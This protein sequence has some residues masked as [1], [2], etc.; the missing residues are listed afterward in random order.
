MAAEE[1]HD[2]PT[3]IG[4]TYT[5]Q[6]PLRATWNSVLS[7]DV[8]MTDTVPVDTASPSPVAVFVNPKAAGG[9]PATEA[10]VITPGKEGGQ[11]CHVARDQSTDAGWRLQPLFGGRVASEV[12]GGTTLA[13]TE[14]A[15]VHVFF[16]DDQGLQ[17]TQLQA[18]GRTWVDP[19]HVDKG[20]HAN[21]RVA[22]SPSGLLVLYGSTPEGDLLTA[23]QEQVGGPFKS[24]VCSMNGAL[25]G[26][27]CSLC[28]TNDHSW[29]LVANVN[30]KPAAYTGVLGGTECTPYGQADDYPGT[31]EEVILGYW[32]N[33]QNSLVFLFVDDDRS[34]HSWSSDA[35]F[36]TPVATPIP[37]SKVKLAAG[38][39]QH[40]DEG[41]TLSL[42]SID[43]QEQLWV[44]HQDPDQPWDDDDGSPRWSPPIALDREVVAVSAD[45]NPAHSPTLFA[46]QAGDA[47]LRVHAKD[48]LTG[49]WRSGSV[50]QA[51]SEMF[52]IE[53]FRTEVN[54]VD[55]KGNPL[56]NHPVTLTLQENQSA[57]DLWIQGTTHQVT[58][59]GP[60][61][62]TTDSTGKL[63]FAILTGAGLAAPTLNLQG[64][65]LPGSHSIAPAGPLHEY[66]SGNGT[67]N[68][69]NPGGPLPTFDADGSTLTAARV[70]GKA[71]SGPVQTNKDLAGVAASAVRNTAQLGLN[72]SLE[73]GAA[74]YVLDLS[75]RAAPR[76]EL[77]E[78]RE[79][80]EL[81]LDRLQKQAGDGVGIS[82]GDIEKWGG[83]VWEGMKNGAIRI[84]NAVVDAAKK[85]ATF[86]VEIGEFAA[87]GVSLAVHGLEQ[88]A[89]FIAG[90]LQGIEA[91]VENVIKWLRA[92]FDFG[93]IWRTKKAFQEA[94]LTTPDYVKALTG[95][96]GKAGDGWF[97]KQKTTVNGHFEKLR[98]NYAGRSFSQLPGWQQPGQGSSGNAVVGGTSPADLTSNV[99][100]NW[101]QDKVSAGAPQDLGVAADMSVQSPWQTFGSKLSAVQGDFVKAVEA[102][103]DGVEAIIKDPTSI[104]SVGISDFL[105]GIEKIVDAALDLADAMLQGLVALT[106]SVMDALKRLLQTTLELG[107]LNKLWAWL[108]KEADCAS[109]GELTVAALM[110]LF[111]AFPT[112]LA[113]KLVAGVESE[114]F[115]DGKLPTPTSGGLLGAM[116]RGCLIA[117]A[118]LRVFSL[119]PASMSDM[120]GMLAPR[121]LTIVNLGITIIIWG[122]SHGFPPL[123]DLQWEVAAAVVATLLW[124]APAVYIIVEAVAETLLRAIK[125]LAGDIG[126]VA[127]TFSG[128]ASLILGA[129]QDAMGGAEGYLAS[130]NILLPL[131]SVFSFLN[132]SVFQGDP[133]SEVFTLCK[134]LM[135]FIGYLGGGILQLLDAASSGPPELSPAS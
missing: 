103:K 56:P 107:P 22:Y 16:Q 19:V 66:L 97:G 120:L 42:Y 34:L 5:P 98:T 28:L 127:S 41:D 110:A 20:V 108:A 67:L 54:L 132:M 130:A 50:L 17:V 79:R 135:N 100:H 87:K 31:L 46:I 10:V 129:V 96:A 3:T 93:A 94:L 58:S 37:N 23:H 118:A 12:A 11:L 116:P 14:D 84:K 7:Q 40:G 124:L 55:G 15:S 61:K 57:A 69:T 63:S 64:D 77:L 62:V 119:V 4:S 89:H 115:P 92:V 53:R 91:A 81:E 75:D 45:M 134:L 128:F 47:A 6:L 83:D 131:P 33:Q 29:A 26:G 90:V 9:Q 88:A 8:V 32:S 21:L 60:L 72:K 1:S 78:T 70:N 99:H 59:Q 106:T 44:L 86:A 25:L 82:W 52:E 101:L 68:P 65:G 73:G 2:V 113:Y 133:L 49:M 112:T 117:A 122:L 104:S 125:M 24:T 71:L 39:V 18:D 43:D 95:K 102:F 74:G 105:E 80:L 30:G 27:D 36:S 85:V 109:D 48:P 111:G 121:W 51:G 38:Y 76:F 13:R 35:Q 114:P 123:S 126:A